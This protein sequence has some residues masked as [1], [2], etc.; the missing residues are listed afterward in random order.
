MK[1]SLNFM[2][3]VIHC[4]FESSGNSRMW[5]RKYNSS[6]CNFWH[7][8]KALCHWWGSVE[9]DPLS[10]IYRSTWLSGYAKKLRLWYIFYMPVTLI[11]SLKNEESVEIA[12]YMATQS[13]NFNA[14]S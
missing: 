13:S 11:F 1:F 5:L 9:L 10:L 14:S 6:L 3:V 2:M 12:V 7:P 4:Q 8:T